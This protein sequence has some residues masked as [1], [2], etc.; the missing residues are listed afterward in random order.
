MFS[1]G[2]EASGAIAF[3]D[4]NGRLVLL[5][6]HKHKQTVQGVKDGLLPAWST[7]GARLA[8]V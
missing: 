3:V 8:W 5:D 7:D 1:W 6:Q 4:S 2:P